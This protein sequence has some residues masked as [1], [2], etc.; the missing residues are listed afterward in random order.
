MIRVLRCLVAVALAMV[1]TGLA[2]DTRVEHHCIGN[3]F[4]A[5]F[6]IIDGPIEAGLAERVRAELA[7][8]E[9]PTVYLNSPGGNL[10][11]AVE[12]GRLIREAGRD[13][14]IGATDTIPKNDLCDVECLFPYGGFP[15]AGVCESACAYAFLGGVVRHMDKDDR[16]GFHRFYAPGRDVTEAQTQII[17]GQ[18]ISYMVEMEVDARLFVVAAGED[19]GSMHYVTREE[20]ETFGII[21]EI[22]YGPFALHPSGAGVYAQSDRRDPPGSYDHVDRVLFYCRGG[23]PFAQIRSTMEA[24][25]VEASFGIGGRL[26]AS[27]YTLPANAL[28]IRKADGHS[29]LAVRL[30]PEIVRGLAVAEEFTLS[31]GYPRVFGGGQGIWLT[32][33]K[34]DRD[35]IAAAFRLCVN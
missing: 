12:I 26:D 24:L 17:A 14:A 11:E 25:T 35:R 18:L 22:G 5:C 3:A 8:F 20:A 15:G 2:A 10:G 27:E 4:E 6:M 16:L 1:G 32:L 19:T 21:T 34:A 7:I 9:G 29:H 28:S 33:T 23:T 31:V 30:S 13:T